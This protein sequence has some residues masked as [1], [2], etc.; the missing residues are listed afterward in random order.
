V[1][2]CDLGWGGTACNTCASDFVSS[3]GSCVPPNDASFTTWPNASSSIN[4]DAWLRAHH[5]EV[6]SLQPRL[7]VVNFAN[8]SNA[9]SVNNL[10]TKIINGFAQGSRPRGYADA[11]ATE[12]MRY[13]LAKPVID[14]RNGFNGN[15]AAPA[16]WPYQ[17]S[18]LMP[19]ESPQQGSWGFN[20]AELFSTTFA[21]YYG[22]E[23]AGS[24]G[25]YHTLCELIDTGKIHELW[26]VSSGDV[27]DVS[28]AEVLEKKQRYTATGNLIPGSFDRCAG[29]G[30]FDTDVPTCAR[31]VKIG[32][33][34]YNRGPG[35]YLHSQGHGMETIGRTSTAVPALA[36]WFVPFGGF[37]FNTRY[38][39]PFSS[40]YAASCTGLTCFSYPTSSS[41]VFKSGST[42]YNVPLYEPVCGNVHFP[43]NARDDYDHINSAQVLSSCQD[44]GRHSGPGGADAKTLVNNSTWALYST[45]D[46]CSGPFLVWW[47]QNMPQSGS[48]QTYADGSPMP[49]FWPFMFY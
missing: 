16:G 41:A 17:N 4:G 14:L 32:F 9:T 44:F 30:C 33:V 49:G 35:C 19:R 1:C 38:G 13:N 5:A 3:G 21:Q 45:Y 28:V 22:Y 23:V 11:G 10:I 2:L 20:Y 42:T 27:P 37:D 29:N 40:L 43:P 18:T 39:L 31:S 8:V 34:N 24:P 25:T 36:K 46:D 47:M 26:I 15:P 6:T 48:G 7:L 12:R